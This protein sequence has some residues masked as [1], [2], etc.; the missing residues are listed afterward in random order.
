MVDDRT[1]PRFDGGH[2]NIARTGAALFLGT[3]AV[4]CTTADDGTL[5]ERARLTTDVSHGENGHCIATQCVDVVAT[6]PLA[7]LALE[8]VDCNGGQLWDLDLQRLDAAGDFVPV[9][10]AAMWGT[11]DPTCIGKAE[12]MWHFHGLER[13]TYRLCTSFHETASAGPF[14]VYARVEGGACA[15]QSSVGMCTACD[16]GRR[17]DQGSGGSTGTG[18]RGTPSG[19]QGAAGGGDHG[20]ECDD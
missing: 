18:G 7:Y 15:G 9:E 12:E 5:E 11:S 10:I 19:G 3:V 14:V 2:M 13:G 1:S 20:D 8:G 4:A 16:D 6:E 17:R